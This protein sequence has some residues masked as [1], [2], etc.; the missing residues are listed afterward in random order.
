MRGQ[1]ASEHWSS[2]AGFILATVG[3]AV[4]LGNIWRFPYLV[5]VSG[6][7][8]F[9]IPYLIGIILCGLP[10][11]MCELA[12]GR[13]YA[14]GVLATFGA[15][16]RPARWAGLM[17]AL[18]ALV[19]LSYY[20]VVAGWAL[21]YTV[22]S[23]MGRV[24]GFTSF[25]AGLNSLLF[26]VLFLGGCGGVVWLGVQRGIEA[27]S[28][29]L[30][31]LLFLMLLGLAGYAGVLPGRH[32]GLQ[33]YLA[34]RLEALADPR[35]WV[36]GFGQVFFSVGVGMGVMIT[37]GSY[38]AP[39]EAIAPAA[40]I[41]TAADVLVALLAGLVIFPIV[42]S[43]GGEPAAGPQLAFETLPMIFRRLGGMAGPI[44]AI[45]FYLLLTVAALTSAVSL[46]ETVLVAL[47]EAT[48]LGRHAGLLW[49]LGLLLLL[50]LPSALS[51]TSVGLTWLGM[52]VL[53]VLDHLTGA[54][55]LPTGVLA[56]ALILGWL[57]PAGV[58][59][60]EVRPGFIG[61]FC[62]LLVRLAVPVAIV[63]VLITAALQPR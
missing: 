30:M 62:L 39:R 59:A 48:G 38:L 7:G 14:G 32:D 56:T 1:T 22:F 63:A 28:R 35:V 44:L 50:G 57:T 19:M 15:V 26:F 17:V 43:F 33:F 9:L 61:W 53:D 11:L 55:L 24:P 10:I 12:G 36:A 16:R 34:P 47:R 3:S 40:G 51:Y 54:V 8:A 42:F 37:Y 4:G 58:L 20:L 25:T 46:L 31:P 45:S 21:G 52:P 49:V 18:W 23:V 60:R 13:R 29:W 41:I 6:G 27:A 2:R 5:G